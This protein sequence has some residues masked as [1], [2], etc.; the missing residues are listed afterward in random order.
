MRLN[1]YCAVWIAVAGL[2]VP[3][4]AEEPKPATPAPTPAVIKPATEPTADETSKAKAKAKAKDKAKADDAT[5]AKL[6]PKKV[7]KEFDANEDGKLTG[8]EAEALR[9]AF[10]GDRRAKLERYDKDGN[11]KLDAEEIAAIKPKSADAAAGGE[12]TTKKAKKKKKP[13]KDA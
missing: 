3:L 8:A 1:A 7:L 5:D 9:K 2:V 10:A 12:D 11:G 6:G 13:A 4:H